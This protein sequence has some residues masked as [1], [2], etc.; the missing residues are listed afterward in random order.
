VVMI[1]PALALIAAR[2]MWHA[3]IEPLLVRVEG[4][5]SRHAD[6]ATGW[7]LALAGIVLARGAI[8]GLMGG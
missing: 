1:A 6:S 7:A 3:G 5:L 2:T 8:A 4:F